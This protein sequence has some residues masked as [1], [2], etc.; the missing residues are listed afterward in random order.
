MKVNLCRIYF[1]KRDDVRSEQRVAMIIRTAVNTR[2]QRQRVLLSKWWCSRASPN[3]LSYF[4]MQA[5]ERVR[6]E[7]IT[8]FAWVQ[9]P[10]KSDVNI[11][12][13]QP[14]IR[15]DSRSRHGSRRAVSQPTR[16]RQQVNAVEVHV[17]QA[18][19]SNKMNLLMET[20]TDMI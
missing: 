18:L 12:L 16:R 14:W 10:R 8:Y 17:I 2:A 13:E 7:K 11:V 4:E 15:F 3:F 1:R 6:G 5:C 20:N 9:R 19:K